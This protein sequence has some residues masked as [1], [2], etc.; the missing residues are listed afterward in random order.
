MGKTKRSERRQQLF[1]LDEQRY[2]L[3]FSTMTNRTRVVLLLVWCV[4]G[5]MLLCVPGSVV[6][7]PRLI[8]N[9]F[10]VPIPGTWALAC[11]LKIHTDFSSP[12]GLAFFLPYLTALKL[13]G[14]TIQIVNQGNALMFMAVS[15]LAFLLLRPPRFSWKICAL[16]I[17]LSS[18]LSANPVFFGD[19][20]TIVSEGS[21]NYVAIGLSCVCLLAPLSK[22][23]KVSDAALLAGILVW[24]TFY[25]LNFLVVGSG[26]IL[27]GLITARHI[28]GTGWLKFPAWL[29]GFYVL[30]AV[31]FVVW[32]HIDLGAMFR[33]IHMAFAARSEYMFS[34]SPERDFHGVDHHGWPAVWLHTTR[35]ITSN[36][37]ELLLIAFMLL[38]LKS[39]GCAGLVAG[40][41]AIDLIQ[42]WFNSYGSSLPTLP[43]IWLC[44]A[45]L[46]P[47]RVP[48]VC[49]SIAVG[50]HLLLLVFG[51]TAAFV[52]DLKPPHIETIQV[53]GADKLYLEP[54]GGYAHQLNEGLDLLRQ[55]GRTNSAVAVLDMFELF[56]FLTGTPPAK[57]MP[58]WLFAEATYNSEH[59][60]PSETIFGRVQTLLVPKHPSSVME[61]Q[62]LSL[63][64]HK[65]LKT[66]FVLAAENDGWSLLDRRK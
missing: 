7:S 27:L 60:L 41:L 48:Q 64:N 28:H 10:F 16:G 23:R 65:Y 62:T 22:V 43:L 12:M 25:K 31:A 55:T 33:D 19:P 1:D 18:L 63:L 15:I 6:L 11:G 30:F 40:V 34:L 32:F 61:L 39:R 37:V 21:V 24:L 29:A 26:F 57:G 51:Y 52:Y 5:P 3:H 20:P 38:W 2:L 49:A 47:S 4:I 14:P 50:V 44:L 36:L 17:G 35:V 8:Q 53:K 45:C 56:P 66:N 42:N 9:D 46:S 54:N 59:H 58:T 13:F